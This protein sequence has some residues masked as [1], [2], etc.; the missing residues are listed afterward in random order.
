M[1]AA[2]DAHSSFTSAR[3]LICLVISISRESAASTA[4]THAPRLYARSVVVLPLV[5]QWH[6]DV[7]EATQA[8]LQTLQT[9]SFSEK[10]VRRLHDPRALLYSQAL[11]RSFAPITLVS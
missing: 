10:E 6:R 4:I 9:R 11:S 8:P 7:K 2:E 1:G 5:C 3:K